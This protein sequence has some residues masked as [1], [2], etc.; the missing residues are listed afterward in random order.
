MAGSWTHRALTPTPSSREA[1]LLLDG[2][3]PDDVP[4][5]VRA[6]SLIEQVPVDREQ[7]GPLV[8]RVL[9]RSLAAVHK[10]ATTS[11]DTVLVLGVPMRERDLRLRLEHTYRALGRKAATNGERVALV[12]RANAVRPRSWW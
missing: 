5:L 9:E 4:D 8:A 6:A 11:T 1:K 10:G 12:E 3:A 2:A 7:R